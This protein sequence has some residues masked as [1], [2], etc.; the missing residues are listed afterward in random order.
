[1]IAPYAALLL[2]ALACVRHVYAA[3]CALP[4]RLAYEALNDLRIA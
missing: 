2:S 3:R 4:V 1:M